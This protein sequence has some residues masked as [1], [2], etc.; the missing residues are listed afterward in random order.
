MANKRMVLTFGTRRNFGIIARHK[1][2]VV[3][4]ALYFRSGR[5]KGRTCEALAL[6]LNPIG[7]FVAAVFVTVNNVVCNC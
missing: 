5:P 2:A 3:L 1:G 7:C 4:Q 6:F